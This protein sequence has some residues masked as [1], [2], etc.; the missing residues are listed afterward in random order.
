[1]LIWILEQAL[2]GK[3]GYNYWW[4]APIYSQST[5]AFTR[6]KRALRISEL[7]AEAYKIIEGTHSI[8]FG[9]G[10]TITFKSGDNPDSLYGEDIYGCV[11]D[12][13]SRVLEESFF[14]IRS[15][16]TATRGKLKIIGNVVNKSNW[17]YKLC[18]TKNPNLTYFK[19]TAMD[20]V[21]AGIMDKQEIDD[22]K[23]I[24]P[25]H[26]FRALY[27]AEAPDDGLNPF[28]ISNIE[29]CTI[30]IDNV[31]TK[32]FSYDSEKEILC[33]GIDVA[34]GRTEASDFTSVIGLT[35]KLEVGRYEIFKG[36]W[37]T[38]L[39]RL[40]NI[41]LDTPAFI[42][43]NSIGSPIYEFL[44]SSCENIEG[45][46]TTSKSKKELI[47]KDLLPYIL[48]HKL[49]I[50]NGIITEELK[51]YEYQEKG[52]NYT[53]NASTGH[54]DCVISLALSIKKYKKLMGESKSSY[55]TV[56]FDI[57]HPGYNT[58]NN[59][60]NS[61]WQKVNAPTLGF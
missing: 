15:T 27:M 56:V 45:F 60:K 48:Q 3:S 26:I 20:A 35:E 14:A 37:R 13:A 23:A 19:L 24:L 31:D 9:N 18:R 38:Q 16:L 52:N 47:E 6:L 2:Q 40:E 28:G 42:E 55:E 11:I 7:P 39:K 34:R 22:A 54:D 43:M 51:N 29:K 12:E 58:L 41:I 1:M 46:N 44:V 4:V 10:A 59:N 53:Y 49:Q 21:E 61:N 50:P 25:D 30:N 32:T 5:I 36:P 17:A 8:E 57:K 33:Y